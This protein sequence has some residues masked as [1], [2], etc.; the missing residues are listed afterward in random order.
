[1]ALPDLTIEA[2]QLDSIEVELV[3]A[4][5]G[6]ARSFERSKPAFER[7]DIVTI[8]LTMNSSGADAP[9]AEIDG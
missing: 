9:A 2:L 7:R 5:P 6:K 8:N 1:M 4:L 3:M